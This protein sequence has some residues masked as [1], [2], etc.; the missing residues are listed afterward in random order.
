ML[1]QG[2][3]FTVVPTAAFKR[4]GEDVLWILLAYV[5][6]MISVPSGAI[7][8]RVLFKPASRC[9]PLQNYAIRFQ[10]TQPEAYLTVQIVMNVIV[11]TPD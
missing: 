4:Q 10:H 7:Y 3:D 6:F 2:N 11:G 8:T 9:L 5:I 1:L